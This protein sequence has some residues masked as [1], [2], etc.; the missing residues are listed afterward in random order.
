MAQPQADQSPAEQHAARNAAI[1]ALAAQQL[2]AAWPKIDWSSPDA[3]ATVKRIYGAI[4]TRYG[5]AS[6]AV[7][8]EFYDQL[9]ETAMPAAKKFRA[10][11]ADPLPIEQLDKVVESAFLGTAA[12][13]EPRV[14]VTVSGE[15]TSD[16]PVEERVP[17]RLEASL[18][19][20]VQQP[21][22]D[23]IAAASDADPQA[24]GYVRVPKGE[25]PCA[26]C[27]MLA[28]REVL[29]LSKKSAGR[30]V[31]RSGRSRTDNTSPAASNTK[32]ET[33]A[34]MA[35]RLLPGLEKSLADLR[36]KGLA[37]S[38]SQIQYHLTQIARLN[39]LL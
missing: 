21:A 4:V 22:R 12:D 10:T 32:P 6:A 16:L 29:Y 14:S 31:G 30:V 37:E 17:A 13:N 23:T 19:R 25:D 9:R 8:A 34:Q 24:V 38:S 2:A 18:Q 20:H 35:K 27:I 15:T 7:A 3:V 36:A 1:V 33:E 39:R 11:P 28:T 5:Q 26:F